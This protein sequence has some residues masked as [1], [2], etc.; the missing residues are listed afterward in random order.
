MLAGLC[1]PVRLRLLVCRTH[2]QV[3]SFGR[4]SSI[5]WPQAELW[6]EWLGVSIV[7]F[8]ELDASRIIQISPRVVCDMHANQETR[9]LDLWNDINPA[10]PRYFSSSRHQQGPVHRRYCVRAISCTGVAIITR[11]GWCQWRRS[12]HLLTTAGLYMRSMKPREATTGTSSISGT[13]TAPRSLSLAGSRS[14]TRAGAGAEK[15]KPSMHSVPSIGY[16]L[17]TPPRIVATCCPS[18]R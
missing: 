13:G 14:N 16:N 5:Y 10:G 17:T 8:A 3:R 9:P 1:W 11:N 7:A 2:H 18:N 6:G 4:L 15:I 12:R